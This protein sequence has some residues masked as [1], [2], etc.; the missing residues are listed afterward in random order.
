MNYYMAIREG[1]SLEGECMVLC[2]YTTRSNYT[3][4]VDGRSNNSYTYD[5]LELIF[6]QFVIKFSKKSEVAPSPY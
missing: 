3:V 4:I 2:I 6:N 5:H 1:K